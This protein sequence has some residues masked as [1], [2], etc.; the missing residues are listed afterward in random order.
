[1]WFPQS[2]TGTQNIKYMGTSLQKIPNNKKKKP[3]TK[4]ISNLS[5][6]ICKTV[7]KEYPSITI[8]KSEIGAIILS[9]YPDLGLI[10]S[11]PP[12]NGLNGSGITTEPS[13]CWLFSSRHTII[14]GTA[15]AVAFN[16]WTN[17][18]GE[19]LLLPFLGFVDACSEERYRI[20][21]RRLW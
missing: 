6:M 4:M 5:W 7:T 19:R 20:P 14:R 15:H 10:S 18:G 17:C 12:I 3:K 11:R 13:S 21:R 8:C 9:S 16:V 1:M 2:T